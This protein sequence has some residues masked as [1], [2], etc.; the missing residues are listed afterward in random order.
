MATLFISETRA[1]WW[2]Y[3][4]GYN[5]ILYLP[6]CYVHACALYI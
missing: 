5:F 4:G 6:T 3:C 1:V 2:K